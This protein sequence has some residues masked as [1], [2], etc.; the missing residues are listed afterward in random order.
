MTGREAL[1]EYACGSCTVTCE[2]LA[3]CHC[4]VERAHII[5]A[6]CIW[7]LLRQHRQL[8]LLTTRS[9]SN[10]ML[11]TIYHGSPAA[12]RHPPDPSW[13]GVCADSWCADRSGPQS[14]YLPGCYQS[15]PDQEVPIGAYNTFFGVPRYPILGLGFYS[16]EVGY[17]KQGHCLGGPPPCNSHYKG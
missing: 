2:P 1:I 7:A 13:P 15:L 3:T 9:I 6:Y 16:H 8:H 11:S 17:P 10:L 14:V 4:L 5:L 12:H